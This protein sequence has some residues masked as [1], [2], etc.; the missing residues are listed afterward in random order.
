MKDKD[1]SDPIVEKNNIKHKKVNK[2]KNFLS[3]IFFFYNL[4]KTKET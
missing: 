2:I 3:N 1:P 4:T